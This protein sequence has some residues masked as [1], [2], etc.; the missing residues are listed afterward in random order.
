MGNHYKILIASFSVFLV[1]LILF[2]IYTCRKKSVHKKTGDV[3]AS[4]YSGEKFRTE[5]LIN[6]PD[7]ENLSIH[8]I[9]DANGEVVGK[10]G[11]GTV[12]KASLHGNNHSLMLLR[13]LRP[14]CT[15]SLK[16]IIPEVQFLGNIRHPNLIPLRAFYSGPRGEKLLVHPFFPRGTVSQFLRSKHARS[17][18]RVKFYSISVGIA[19][20]LE[21]LHTGLAKPLVHGNLKSKNILLDANYQPCLSDFGI[22]LLLNPT[23]NQEMLESLDAEGYKAAELIKMKEANTE[24]DIYS[25]GIILL[26]LLT[27]K[28]PIVV[29]PTSGQHLHLPSL[30]RNAII[31]QRVSEIFDP[32][33]LSREDQNPVTEEGLLLYFQLAMSCCA[34]SSSFRPDIQQIRRQLEEIGSKGFPLFA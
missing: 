6:F 30:M 1:I 19:K 23:A 4:P 29:D 25:L 14:V 16:D 28:E 11:Y 15:R 20:G 27:G 26:E 32:E 33:L 10:S 17:L 12:Y 5:E 34:P 18:R 24:S 2:I 8:D 7:G 22:H 31:S 21:Y 9:L 3:E 13:F